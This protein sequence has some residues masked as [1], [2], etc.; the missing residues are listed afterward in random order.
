MYHNYPIPD[1][2]RQINGLGFEV[3]GI[4]VSS[5]AQDLPPVDVDHPG[6]GT[7]LGSGW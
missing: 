7:G 1:T 3:Y 4:S 2:C 6:G 5:R